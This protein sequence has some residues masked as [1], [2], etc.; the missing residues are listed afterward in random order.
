MFGGFFG[1]TWFNPATDIRK[2]LRLPKAHSIDSLFVDGH[3][4]MG[5][6]VRSADG[7]TLTLPYGVNDIRLRFTSGDYI[8]EQNKRY[9]YKINS[10]DWIYADAPEILLPAPEFGSYFIEAISSN[11]SGLWSDNVLSITIYIKPPIWMSNLAFLIYVLVAIVLVFIFHR[12]KSARLRQLNKNLEQKVAIKTDELA[13][14]NIF[15]EQSIKQQERMFENTSHDLKTP[16]SIISSCHE[17]IKNYSLPERVEQHLRLATKHS[18]R[19]KVIVNQ[20]L[21]IERQKL[22]DAGPNIDLLS[23]IIAEVND[24]KEMSNQRGVTIK[25]NILSQQTCYLSIPKATLVTIIGNILDNA[26]KYSPKRGGTVYVSAK[27]TDKDIMVTIID[28]GLGFKD[29]TKFGKRYY[30][31]HKY[32]DGSGIGVSSAIELVHRYNGTITANNKHNDGFEVH[33]KL[34]KTVSQNDSDTV[35]A[36]KQVSTESRDRSVDQIMNSGRD[37]PKILYVEDDRDMAYIFMEQC[38]NTLNIIH[39]QDGQDAKNILKNAQI[40]QLP[41]AIVSDVMMPNMNGYDLCSW[42]KST[43]EFQHIPFLLLTAKT[44]TPSQTQGLALGAD[45]Y[46]DKLIPTA[47]L[48]QKIVN[49]VNTVKAK[50]RLLSLFASSTNYETFDLDM[51]FVDPFVELVR[52]KLSLHFSNSDYRLADLCNSLHKSESTVARN[53]LKYFGKTFSELLFER[54]MNHAERLL[55]SNL[56]ISKVAEQCGFENFSYFSKRFKEKYSM[57]PSAYRKANKGS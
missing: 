52:D 5:S 34:P 7:Q 53:L 3:S 54:R 48:I 21:A 38:F 49:I 28:E 24:R 29:I 17:L 43:K 14:K 30:R 25:H 22:F 11:S 40:T 32:L 42:V 55:V 45:D 56:Q 16:I 35:L 51:E 57:S 18:E 6:I 8:A 39:A 23:V 31:E 36:S 50:E 9:R 2:N 26:I 12:A 4:M 46:I 10:G 47:Q 37:V 19:L 20:I 41:V 33:I 15:L 27:Q 44:D 1:L 13:K